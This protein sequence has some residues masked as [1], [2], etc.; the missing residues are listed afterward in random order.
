MGI[1]S[2]VYGILN[3][4]SRL[5]IKHSEWGNGSPHNLVEL[6]KWTGSW[7]TAMLTLC[8]RAGRQT[9]LCM[10][11]RDALHVRGWFED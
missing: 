9:G 3:G 8:R 11:C 1:V 10:G 2:Y 5:C 6:S 7:H 4:L